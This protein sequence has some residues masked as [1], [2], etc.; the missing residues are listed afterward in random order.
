[1]VNIQFPEFLRNST[2]MA[3][4]NLAACQNK[5]PV[6]PSPGP[7]CP[8]GRLFMR[9]TLTMTALLSDE[10]GMKEVP[11]LAGIA[12]WPSGPWD[13][14]SSSNQ[15]D[16]GPAMGHANRS[17]SLDMGLESG[18]FPPGPL[19]FSE[20]LIYSFKRTGVPNVKG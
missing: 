6:W 16:Q 15:R 17:C 13:L 12:L 2:L 8:G 1:M 10:Q 7:V 9:I 19:T 14:L 3:S 11:Y 20:K 4:R 5:S 18:E